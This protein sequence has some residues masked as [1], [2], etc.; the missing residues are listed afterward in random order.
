LKVK[1]LELFEEYS[2]G[3]AAYRGTYWKCEI[4]GATFKLFKD[5]TN[6]LLN[7]HERNFEDILDIDFNPS[8]RYCAMEEKY[9]ERKYPNSGRKRNKT[10]KT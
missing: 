8:K 10:E 2:D 5:A 4:C 6:H 1:K 7:F 3:K 9:F